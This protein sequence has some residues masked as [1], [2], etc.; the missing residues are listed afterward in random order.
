MENAFIFMS[1]R[2]FY[3]FVSHCESANVCFGHSIQSHPSTPVCR[4]TVQ[5]ALFVCLFVLLTSDY[6]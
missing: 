3:E 5:S 1:V 6:V 4:F 2:D